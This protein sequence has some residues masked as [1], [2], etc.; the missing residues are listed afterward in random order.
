MGLVVDYIVIAMT[1]GVNWGVLSI[2]TKETTKNQLIKSASRL[3]IFVD[4]L[5]LLSVKFMESALIST[6]K[7]FVFYL[8]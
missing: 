2:K 5:G 4:N 6:F 7:R 8:C 3:S 1:L